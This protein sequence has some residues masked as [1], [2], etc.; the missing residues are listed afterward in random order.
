MALADLP[1]RGRSDVGTLSD[2]KPESVSSQR[3]KRHLKRSAL[4]PRHQPLLLHPRPDGWTA[5]LRASRPKSSC[6]LH[7]KCAAVQFRRVRHPNPCRK[8]VRHF[9]GQPELPGQRP[10]GHRIFRF[11]S[12]R[13]TRLTSTELAHLNSK[14]RPIFFSRFSSLTLLF[15]V[16]AGE[17]FVSRGAAWV[18]LRPQSVPETVGI[19]VLS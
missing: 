9:S 1:L 13:P 3:G 10:Y 11:S 7:W 4:R 17:L 2:G 8:I 12:Q 18:I 16:R 15:Q 14:T 5:Q 6:D 19:S